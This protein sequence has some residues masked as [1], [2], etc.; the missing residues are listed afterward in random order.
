MLKLIIVDDEY[1]VRQGM[2]KIVPWD[3]MNIAIAGEA[4][5]VEDATGVA[6]RVYP[7][8]VICDIRLPGGEGFVLIDEIRKIVPW[9]Q[10]IM[11]TAHADKEYMR[12][13][14]YNGVCDYLFKPAMVEDIKAAVVRA[15]GKVLEFQEK[16]YQD[17]NNQNFIME[18]LE[19]LREKFVD[20]L[21]NGVRKEEKV[22][23]DGKSLR[24]YL[25]GP[26]YRLLQVKAET[27][28]TGKLVQQMS[29]RLREWHP[30]FTGPGGGDGLVYAVLNCRRGEDAAHIKEQ[31][32]ETEI[33]TLQLSEEYFV[34]TK[35]A[36]EYKK[37]KPAEPDGG[38]GEQET[39]L[40]RDDELRHIKETLYEAVKYHDAVE[41]IQRLFEE[42]LELAQ[43]KQIA[44]KE[45]VKQGRE[46]MEMIRVLTGVPK[47]NYLRACNISDSKE[48]F[49]E[50]CKQIQDANIYLLDD[51]SG[52][53]LYYIKKRYMEDLSLEQIAAELFMSSSYLSRI[54]KERTGNGFGYW[55]HFYRIETAKLQ[56]LKA[57]KSIEQVASECG[58]HSYRI[59]SEHFRKY[60][61]Q[62]ASAWRTQR[63]EQE[64]RQ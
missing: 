59:F 23:Q 53:A 17:Q 63:L 28:E 25:E 20:D 61:G 24:L 5:S 44:E 58:Y 6:G 13:A 15:Q 8:I 32:A 27:L 29:I 48:K 56:L 36:G 55:L 37:M 7:D 1:I 19:V 11:I 45:I 18:N 33:D 49:S 2:R 12:K 34:I 39:A 43:K 22:F 35:L 31:L 54:M 51:V 50:L 4:E 38:Q 26:V 57:D 10:F 52:K 64:E 62:T 21:L 14:I 42:Y 3:E 46:I 30:V 41:E 16:M 9:V 40:W 47:K 60:T